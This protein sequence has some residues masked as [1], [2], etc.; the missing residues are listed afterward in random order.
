MADQ[1]P[2]AR[3]A[4]RGECLTIDC[5][6]QR[7]FELTPQMQDCTLC[8]EYICRRPSSSRRRR[9]NT[10][11]LKKWAISRAELFYNRGLIEFQLKNYS[12]AA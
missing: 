8:M 7:A 12:Q 11:E 6:F 1:A 2:C 4:M 9:K 10:P 3:Q 5:Y